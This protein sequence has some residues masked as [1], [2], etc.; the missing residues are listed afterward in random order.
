SIYKSLSTFCYITSKNITNLRYEE[1]AL[2]FRSFLRT[3]FSLPLGIIF[4]IVLRYIFNFSSQKCSIHFHFLC[5]ISLEISHRFI[6][7][8]HSLLEIIFGHQALVMSDIYLRTLAICCMSEF[9]CRFRFQIT[10][11]TFKFMLIFS[12][13][14]LSE[15]CPDFIISLTREGQSFRNAAAS[16]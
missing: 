11:L 3:M 7:F 9:V 13:F 14:N 2:Y 5:L 6:N 8:H 16:S 1:T 4:H 10:V 12:I 15:I